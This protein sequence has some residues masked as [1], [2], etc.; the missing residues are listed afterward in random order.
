MKITEEIDA[1][2]TLGISP[3]NFLVTPRI[4]AVVIAMP[5][6]VVYADAL[7]ILGGMTVAV[8][9]L[10]LS[11]TQFM[12][13][14]LEP[15]VLADGLVGIVKA[16]VYGVIVGLAGCMRGLQTGDDASAV[17]NATTSAVVTGIILIVFA[18]AVL[19]WMAALLQV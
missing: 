7:G 4:L 18:N 3:I 10:D 1:L 13:G 14:L 16:V 19:D 2:K 6:L 8:M 5:L 17:G 11:T 9:M 12:T 15:V